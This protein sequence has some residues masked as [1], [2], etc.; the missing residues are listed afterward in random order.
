M[1]QM[2]VAFVPAA[3]QGQR[4]MQKTHARS[5]QRQTLLLVHLKGCKD[6]TQ[7]QRS[8]QPAAGR[9][10][11]RG[12]CAHGYDREMSSTHCNSTIKYTERRRGEVR[13]REDAR[14]GDWTAGGS[15]DGGSL[16]SLGVGT[17]S[18]IKFAFRASNL[19]GAMYRA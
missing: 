16:G 11:L 6:T 10:G 15:A 19:Q 8:R 3:G 18:W 4:E 14:D 7:K 1:A 9:R 5:R 13:K 17:S 12:E 2:G